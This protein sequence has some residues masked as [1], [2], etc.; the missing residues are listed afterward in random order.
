MAYCASTRKGLICLQKSD[1]CIYVVSNPGYTNAGGI[2]CLHHRLVSQAEKR[3]PNTP[4]M[5]N[6]ATTNSNPHIATDT[7]NPPANTP[8]TVSPDFRASRF[9]ALCSSAVIGHGCGSP[10]PGH[11][12]ADRAIGFPHVLH[13]RSLSVSI[14]PA[15]SL[16]ARWIIDDCVSVAQSLAT[17]QHRQASAGDLRADRVPAP[18]RPEAW[19][20]AEA[21]IGP[22]LSAVVFVITA[23]RSDPTWPEERRVHTPGGFFRSLTRLAAGGR[24][25]LAASIHGIVERN[26]DPR[27]HQD[28]P[29]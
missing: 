27:R 11:I 21:M 15:P 29:R 3:M 10:Q 7:A 25:D 1:L 9:A 12:V 14:T 26:L 6:V 20:D 17:K 24:A 19:R 13:G 22:V 5:S 23:T 4:M 18:A 16:C 8:R 28:S 2:P